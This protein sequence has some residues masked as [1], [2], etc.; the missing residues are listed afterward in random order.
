MTM[1]SIFDHQEILLHPQLVLIIQL[2]CSICS[3]CSDSFCFPSLIANSACACSN[4]SFCLG[5]LKKIFNFLNRLIYF[6]AFFKPLITHNCKVCAEQDIR[7]VLDHL[8]NWT[9]KPLIG[10]PIGY[11]SNW[12][13]HMSKSNCFNWTLEMPNTGLTLTTRKIKIYFFIFSFRFL[14][15][16]YLLLFIFSM[17]AESI[18]NFGGVVYTFWWS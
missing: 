3:I 6:F 18:I 9:Y 5:E 11:M 8:D 7:S 4:L 10:H 13:F 2:I 12:T 15:R 1:Y 16:Y 17:Q 14:W